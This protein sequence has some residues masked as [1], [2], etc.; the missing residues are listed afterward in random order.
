MTTSACYKESENWWGCRVTNEAERGISDRP[1]VL[2]A[3]DLVG[4]H[5]Q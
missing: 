3:A 2:A 4:A 5:I 1:E